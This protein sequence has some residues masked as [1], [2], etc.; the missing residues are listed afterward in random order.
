MSELQPSCHGKRKDDEGI[1]RGVTERSMDVSRVHDPMDIAYRRILS[2]LLLCA[3]SI[4]RSG[5]DTRNLYHLSSSTDK[6]PSVQKYSG[7]YSIAEANNANH[8][9]MY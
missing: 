8:G 1:H 2:V 9:Q 6:Q 3:Y 5:L 7:T 4:P